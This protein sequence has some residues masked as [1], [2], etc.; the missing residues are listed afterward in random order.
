[1]GRKDGQKM[2]PKKHDTKP[3]V[4]PQP[5]TAAPTASAPQ[6][7]TA[8]PVEPTKQEKAIKALIIALAESG[9]RID[10]NPVTMDGK[11]ALVRPWGPAPTIKIGPS[12]SYDIIEVRSFAK[13]DLPTML[14][15]KELYDKRVA[16]EQKKAAEA[17]KP[18]PAPTTKPES[19]PI[20]KETP[21]ARKAKESEQLEKQLAHA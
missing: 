1:M 6:A 4:K 7:Q 20:A 9:L 17:S 14:K 2:T 11:F 16:R 12:G 3:E 15:A 5:T 10:A 21:T 13:A 19:K 8:K 18:A